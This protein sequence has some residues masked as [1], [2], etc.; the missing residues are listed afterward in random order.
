MYSH[1]EYISWLTPFGLMFLTA[2]LVSWWLARRNAISIGVD[3]SHIDL[4]L[5]VSIIVG[6]AGA[7]F[8]SRFMPMD[9]MI[10]GE[11]MQAD[12]R[13]RLFSMLG[14]GVVAVLIYSR[15]ARLPFRRLLDVFALPT[16]A[17]L[18][19]HRVGC[20]L[21]GCCWGDLVSSEPVTRFATQVQ[22]LPFLGGLVSGISYPP[23]SLAFEQHVAM[24][25]IEPVASAS[26]PVYP[27][28]LFES[29]LLFVALLALWRMP[30]RRLP[31]GL[32]TVSAVCAYAFTRF[33]LEY[34]RADGPIIM[35]NLTVTQLQCLLL[36]LSAVL[37]PGLVGQAR[38]GQIKTA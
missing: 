22:T 31:A 14:C 23:G 1:F 9:S 26:L 33:F 5:P 15:I 38:S 10:A 6:L 17:G 7:V 34:L 32:L 25:L 11:A 8:L 18:M 4:L 24:G 30:W 19:I 35:G 27:V 3:G 12:V 2:I 13:V 28:Q 20:F 36:M 29:A 21:A 37:L 16:I